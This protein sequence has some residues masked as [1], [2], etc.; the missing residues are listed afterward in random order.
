M[1]V[2]ADLQHEA[3]RSAGLEDLL[4][5]G[6]HLLHGQAA[7]RHDLAEEQV[8]EQRPVRE[9]A[10]AVVRRERRRQLR[11]QR[12]GEPAAR[13]QH[14][15]DERLVDLPEPVP[16]G[17]QPQR[18]ADQPVAIRRRQPEG[19]PRPSRAT[20]LRVLGQLAGRQQAEAREELVVGRDVL[21]DLDHVPRHVDAE[22]DQR[23]VQL[24]LGD[25]RPEVRMLG[26]AARAPAPRGSCG[27]R[28]CSRRST[29]RTRSG[30]GRRTRRPSPASRRR[31]APPRGVAWP[32][33]ARP[34]PGA[35]PR[36]R[37]CADRTRRDRPR[38][39]PA[40]PR[41]GRP[42][43]APSDPTRR[44]ATGRASPRCPGRARSGARSPRPGGAGARR[45]GCPAP[46]P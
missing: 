21:E 25:H 36:R 42:R 27:R 4:H 7:R 18:E 44:G 40:A 26:E 3:R 37:G 15:G 17:D 12:L 34:P 28:G 41:P 6:V 13:R 22:L 1:V 16:G 33:S 29:R 46:S 11:G 14:L 39:P 45:P 19:A 9:V 5:D 43:P 38:G 35:G 8:V 24:H 10:L 32:G 2:E 30:P 23:P 31:S 20:H